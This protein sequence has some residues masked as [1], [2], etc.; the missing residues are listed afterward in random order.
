M[1][2]AAQ[3]SLKSHSASKFKFFSK[4]ITIMSQQVYKV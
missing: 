1:Q 3:N 4:Y 2:K